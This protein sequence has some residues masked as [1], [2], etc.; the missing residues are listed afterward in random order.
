MKRGISVRENK[1][2]TRDKSSNSTI[3][4]FESPPAHKQTQLEE[5]RREKEEASSAEIA[6]LSIE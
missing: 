5:G 1:Y 2:A 4:S 3:G 6:Q